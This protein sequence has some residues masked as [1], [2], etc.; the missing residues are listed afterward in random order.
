MALSEAVGNAGRNFAPPGL[1]DF[2][3]DRLSAQAVGLQISRVIRTDK[4]ELN[5]PRLTADAGAKWAAEGNDLTTTDPASDTVTATRASSPRSSPSPTRSAR[6]ASRRP[7]RCS[8]R[9]SPG[10]SR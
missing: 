4:R 7:C 3:F 8:A 9:A 10:A 1:A 6:T 5:V 2:F